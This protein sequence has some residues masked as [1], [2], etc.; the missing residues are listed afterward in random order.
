MTCFAALSFLFACNS[1]QTADQSLNDD[2]QRKG[3][4]T[5]IVHH[6]PY[7][8]EMMQEMMNNDSCKQMMVDG[9]MGN[10]GMMK[11]MMNN[12][13]MHSMMMDHMMGMA[14][15]DSSMC[16]MMMDKTMDMCSDD[17]SKCKMMMGSMQSHP[18]VMKSMKG[19]CGMD[20]MK[21]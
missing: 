15:T 10:S 14:K 8:N 7:M 11:M 20:N 12:S 2:S 19:N 17:P 6:S 3:I 1:K 16:K 18:T 21:K 5:S 4:I 9:I 13:S